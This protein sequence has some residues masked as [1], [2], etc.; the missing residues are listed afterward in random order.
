[1]EKLFP[2]DWKVSINCAKYFNSTPN[3]V[4]CGSYQN[5]FIG[6][7]DT[8]SNNNSLQICMHAPQSGN[9]V[10][11]IQPIGEYLVLSGSRREDFIHLWDL[12]MQGII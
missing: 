3:M 8:R 7:C 4:A 9:G 11:Q 6:I 5:N 10:F 1:M 2:D 12:R